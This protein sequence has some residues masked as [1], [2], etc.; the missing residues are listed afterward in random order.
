MAETR[1]TD[2]PP[3]P[4]SQVS[5]PRPRL[6]RPLSVQVCTG[7][8]VTKQYQGN[9]NINQALLPCFSPACPASHLPGPSSTLLLPAPPSPQLEE[10][11]EHHSD[12]VTKPGFQ[13]QCPTLYTPGGTW[14]LARCRVMAA[15]MHS[16]PPARTMASFTSSLPAMARRALSTCFTRSYMEGT[17][18]VT[19]DADSPLPV[20]PGLTVWLLYYG[21]G[22]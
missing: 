8:A 21:R 2:P 13:T 5:A 1:P 17:K 3:S 12:I 14:G 6:D 7:P 11:E 10:M 16:V 18:G 15:T 9:K 20:D 4:T 22:C 19:P